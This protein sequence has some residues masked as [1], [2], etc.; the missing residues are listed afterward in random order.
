MS[1]DQELDGIFTRAATVESTVVSLIGCSDCSGSM[2]KSSSI[3]GI[4]PRMFSVV[5][6]A[7][8]LVDDIEAMVVW[9]SLSFKS[10]RNNASLERTE[11]GPRSLSSD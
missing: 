10:A 9:A 6:R 2:S 4:D 8:V 7:V 3:K 1:G 11:L 5:S